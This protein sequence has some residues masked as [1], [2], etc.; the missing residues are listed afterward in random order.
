MKLRLST[1]GFD[2]YYLSTRNGNDNFS[3]SMAIR[4]NKQVK[5]EAVIEYYFSSVKKTPRLRLKKLTGIFFL[6]VGSI[7][8]HSEKSKSSNKRPLKIKS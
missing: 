7:I 2:Q 8:S 3:L 6:S 5:N 4:H 1:H